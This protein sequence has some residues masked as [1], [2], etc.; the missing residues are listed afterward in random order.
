MV[1]IAGYIYT[2]RIPAVWTTKIGQTVVWIRIWFGTC[3][4]FFGAISY[5]SML[6]WSVNSLLC[7]ENE[8]ARG[9]RKRREIT[10]C[11]KILE[12]AK[13][14]G[15]F[16][17]NDCRLNTNTWPCFTIYCRYYCSYCITSCC[18][19]YVYNTWISFDVLSQNLYEF[20]R[21]SL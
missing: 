14:H 11:I 17:R 3:M 7:I 9:R 12:I 4:P 21:G 15:I 19:I 20:S 6:I 5:Q 8:T 2:Q 18:T 16:W 10:K 13:E 1:A